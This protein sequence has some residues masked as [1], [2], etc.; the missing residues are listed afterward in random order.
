VTAR[1]TF[2][3]ALACACFGHDPKIACLIFHRPDGRGFEVE[4]CRRCGEELT[5]PIQGEAQLVEL[6]RRDLE[7]G[8]PGK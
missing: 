6:L 4:R 1:P 2:L 5:S 7:A 8:R 3:R